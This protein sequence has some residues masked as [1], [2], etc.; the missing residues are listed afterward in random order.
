MTRPASP[1]PELAG[2]RIARLYVLDF[3]LFHV[4]AGRTIGIPGLLLETD[5]GARILIDT[6]FPDA[7]ASDPAIAERD[8]LPRFGHLIDHSHDRTLAGQLALLGLRP[9]DIT[10]AILTHSHIDHVGSLPHVAHAPIVMMEAERAEPH[11][12]YF[13]SVRP[14]DWPEADYRLIAAEG[15]LCH[16]LTLIP[17]PGHTVG[18]LS[19]LVTLADT[20]P[21]LIAA[22]AI[23]RA[24]EPAEGFPDADDPETA[25][26]S[27]ERLFALE[28]DLAAWLLWGHEPTQ[29]PELL[30]APA[31]YA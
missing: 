12:L 28:R 24:S 30:K 1:L 9:A 29:W 4:N 19:L 25:R 10:A 27:A 18:H 8:G 5:R 26:R 16:G 13:D 11:P 21:I 15:P 17:T 7:Y 6:G 22:D 3:G 23:N 20:G 31:F 14:M 2:H